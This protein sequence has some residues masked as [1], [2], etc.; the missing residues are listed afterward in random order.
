MDYFDMREKVTVLPEKFRLLC[1]GMDFT[2]TGGIV[3]LG[4]PPGGV[5]LA[6][7]VK[8]YIKAKDKR[9][10]KKKYFIF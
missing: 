3:S 6:H 5:I 7:F 1:S 10:S 2:K 8:K 4:P 9:N